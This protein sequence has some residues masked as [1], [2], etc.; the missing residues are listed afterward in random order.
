[1]ER[2][3]QLMTERGLGSYFERMK[4]LARNAIHVEPIV[5][6][7]DQIP[8]GASKF[9]GLPDL[10]DSF[11]WPRSDE[12]EPLLFLCQFN[13]AELAPYDRD[14]LLPREGMLYI[15]YDVMTMP[16][17]P[18]DGYEGWAV[19]YEAGQE[20]KR[21]RGPEDVP[22]YGA[23][24]RLELSPTPELPFLGSG[25]VPRE[26]LEGREYWDLLGF[27]D[28]YAATGSE[29][30]NSFC[31]LLGHS[32]QYW[33]DSA[34]DFCERAY[35]KRY[36]AEGRPHADPRHPA[37]AARWIN[38]LQLDSCREVGWIFDN[39]YGRVFFMIDEDDLKH[40]RFDRVMVWVDVT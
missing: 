29:K 4:H 19:R 22:G 11:V 12:G 25:L 27:T 40:C 17:V 26:M 36:G 30:A 20:L 31:K 13:L 21:R 7:G 32:Y 9:G 18:Y 2:L 6:P 39:G 23:Y 15:F 16:S 10:P 37:C 1:M 38:L 34:E 14:A 35:R 28:R 8:V 3:K 24:A 33:S 5:T